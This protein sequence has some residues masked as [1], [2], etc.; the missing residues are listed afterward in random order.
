MLS[1]RNMYSALENHLNSLKMGNS[2]IDWRS[3]PGY[4]FVEYTVDFSAT[5]K[6]NLPN[7]AKDLNK[8]YNAFNFTKHKDD[9]TL[10]VKFV[11][12]L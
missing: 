7:F 3:N 9:Q 4:G 1:G 6:T 11:I 12:R 10:S 8:K 2:I 5:T